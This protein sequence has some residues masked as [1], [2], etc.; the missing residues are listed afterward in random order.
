MRSHTSDPTTPT[1]ATRDRLVQKGPRRAVHAGGPL[2]LAWHDATRHHRRLERPAGDLAL[3][4]HEE[5]VA[6][7]R[8]AAADHYH[9]GIEHVEQVAD[10]HAEELGGV[11]HDLQR[12]LVAL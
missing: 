5:V 12:Q 9:L 4:R 3:K 8:H 1:L 2:Q 11:V 10:A 7:E 6:R